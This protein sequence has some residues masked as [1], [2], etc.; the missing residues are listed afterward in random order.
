MGMT[1]DLAE[2]YFSPWVQS[3]RAKP[4]L[5]VRLT[6]WPQAMVPVVLHALGR[7]SNAIDVIAAQDHIQLGSDPLGIVPGDHG[8]FINLRSGQ[9]F[10]P[11]EA[12]AQLESA[13]RMLQE[14]VAAAP[15]NVPEGLQL[16]DKAGA[17]Q[18]ERNQLPPA[19]ECYLSVKAIATRFGLELHQEP[20][21]KR[22]ER[23]RTRNL[24]K[25]GW[26]QCQDRVANAPKYVYELTAVQSVVD[27]YLVKVR[28]PTR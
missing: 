25:G 27:E 2:L 8:C 18:S 5:Y 9:A 23:W 16:P 6:G 28:Q 26:Q 19:G 1:G 10:A 12:I 11:T 24:L 7:F 13:T 3:C 4:T 22:L 15:P 21:R 14:A 17:S 20:L